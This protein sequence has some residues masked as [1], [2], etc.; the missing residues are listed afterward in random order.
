M[1]APTK[2]EALRTLAA[3]GR[4]PDLPT[5]EPSAS[6]EDK[7]QP[8][9][10]RAVLKDRVRIKG[11]LYQSPMLAAYHNRDVI[12]CEDTADQ[13]RVRVLDK[14]R[15][16]I[17]DAFLI[18]DSPSSQ[19]APTRA[20]A[21]QPTVSTEAAPTSSPDT[22]G[23]NCSNTGS[24]PPGDAP[25]GAA[26]QASSG[27]EHPASSHI[28]HVPDPE[29]VSEFNYPEGAR[30]PTSIQLPPGLSELTV[31]IDVTLP[32]SIQ[33]HATTIAIEAEPLPPPLEPRFALWSD[34]RLQMLVEGE[35]IILSRLATKT[36][37]QYLDVI[38]Y[39]AVTEP[40]P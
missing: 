15:D 37:F 1:K 30:V 16:L 25:D 35:E 12:V 40:R 14:K 10:R 38:N 34:G 32:D 7:P 4:L 5:R 23:G 39:D 9:V 8:G 17:C 29:A 24:P 27:P 26:A 28:E 18:I 6:R 21:D 33:E 31:G 3:S 22:N 36:L 11:R 2:V 19:Q 13:S 20:T